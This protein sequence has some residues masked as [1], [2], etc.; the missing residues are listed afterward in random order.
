GLREDVSGWDHA[1]VKTREEQ[2]ER[3]AR[4]DCRLKPI[5]TPLD[6]GSAFRTALTVAGLSDFRF[7]DLRHCAATNPRRVGIDTTTAMQIVIHTSPQMW[8][9][10][11]QI[12]EEDLTQA[13]S[14][15]G[16]Y[17]QENTPG[18]LDPKAESL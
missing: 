11:N 7:H 18:T 6:G 14:K 16:K 9:R 3:S 15:L 13:A 2:Q 17:L 5:Y 8:K 10:Y 12:R 4:E 1:E